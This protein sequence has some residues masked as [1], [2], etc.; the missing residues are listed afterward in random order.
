[1]SPSHRGKRV[2]ALFWATAQHLADRLVDQEVIYFRPGRHDLADLQVAKV[3]RVG[4]DFLV[5]GLTQRAAFDRL[6]NQVA[7]L[8][9]RVRKGLLVAGDRD[10]EQ[11]Q[12]ASGR[13]IEEPD[14]RVEQPR[15]D[16]QGDRE[17]REHPVP[18][19]DRPVLGDLF[20]DHD[21]QR[22][23]DGE[24][25]DQR[26]RVGRPLPEMDQAKERE[27]HPF[28]RGLHHR[29]QPQAGD[30]HAELRG[31]EIEPQVLLNLQRDGEQRRFGGLGLDSRPAC[32]DG[33]ELGGD[34]IGVQGHQ[35]QGGQD[36]FKGVHDPTFVREPR[37]A[38]NDRSAARAER[39]E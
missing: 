38:D 35:R 26:G 1:M 32:G 25:D 18:E 17:E 33:A 37:A 10:A 13:R 14:D 2:K 3:E 9:G 22:G 39:R 8:V 21:V 5:A 15:E 31:G 24:R 36:I 7:Q 34:E 19:L 16:D 6:L 12:D 4:Q 20:P 27:Q 23:A 29:A 28:E 11:R 30:R